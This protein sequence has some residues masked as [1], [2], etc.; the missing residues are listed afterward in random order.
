MAIRVDVF[1]QWW[2]S[3]TEVA[4]DQIPAAG[5]NSNP[6]AAGADLFG[7]RDGLAGR[8]SNLRDQAWDEW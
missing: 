4:G 1:D 7:K 3:L 5:P 6:Q 8:W 2:A